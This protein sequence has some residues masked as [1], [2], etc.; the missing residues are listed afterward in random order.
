MST[1]IVYPGTF[2]PITHGHTDLVVRAARVFS[3]VIVAVAAHSG[4][5]TVFSFKQRV[6][7]AQTV[8]ANYSEVNNI[9][10]VG[11][12][13][14]L[15]E[16]VKQY[17]TRLVL[18]GL[19]AV[20]DFE[21]EFQLANINRRLLPDLENIFLMPAE[22]YMFISSSLVRQVSLLGGDVTQFVHPVV[23]Q[24]LAA[25]RAQSQVKAQE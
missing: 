11:F 4:K 20:A 5:Q 17:N 14:L 8:L 10:V 19:R 2:D 25:W 13:C 24:A 15:T 1:V 6:E 9:E 23:Q 3:K 16:F 7:L 21:Y 12:D 18:R 22:N